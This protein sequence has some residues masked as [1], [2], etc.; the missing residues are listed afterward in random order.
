MRVARIRA[1][2]VRRG[3]PWLRPARS[4]LRNRHCSVTECAHRIPAALGSRA[5]A[6]GRAAPARRPA[7][8]GAC[9]SNGGR[10]LTSQDAIAVWRPTHHQVC[11]GGW[12]EKFLLTHLARRRGLTLF[13]AS[14]HVYGPREERQVRGVYCVYLHI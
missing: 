4:S 3:A 7:Y 10:A 9:V 5:S 12:G 2:S 1:A 8:A 13:L 11:A 14:G 6:L